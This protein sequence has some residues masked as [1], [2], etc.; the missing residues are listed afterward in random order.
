M[1][2][3]PLLPSMDKKIGCPTFLHLRFK[4][5]HLS[6]N[7]HTCFAIIASNVLILFSSKHNVD[8]TT[9]EFSYFSFIPQRRYDRIL[10]LSWKSRL[11]KVHG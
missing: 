9:A 1:M 8:G 3:G 10:K 2:T 6:Y 4:P 11:K 7:I 5:I